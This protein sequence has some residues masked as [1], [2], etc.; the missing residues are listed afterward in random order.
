MTRPIRKY[1]RTR[2]LAGSRRQLGDEDLEDASFAEIAGRH[3]VVEEK[4]DGANAAISFDA[5]GALLL[6]SR[7]H[8]LVGGPRER[9]FALLK[10]WAAALSDRFRE[11]LGPR[12]VLYGEW[13]YAKHTIFYDALPHYFMEFDALDLQTDRFLDTPSR[14]RL[15]SGLPVASAPVLHEG[16]V[17]NT[18]ALARL[19][20]RSRYK[21][22][23]WRARLRD[24]AA[25]APHDRAL[26]ERQTDPSEDMEGLYVKVEE[27]GAVQ[28]RF[29]FVR[30]GFLATVIA[31]DSHWRDRP[32]LPNALSDGVDLFGGV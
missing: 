10:R 17:A 30:A 24:A 13:L 23:R 4:L 20:G 31:S 5:D 8:Y 28:G 9:H 16:V 26:V 14:R 29:K 6:Q 3:L 2:H 7:G 12:Y 32:I 1:P 25:A 19:I 18:A 15:L 11:V 22:E 21:T 27:G